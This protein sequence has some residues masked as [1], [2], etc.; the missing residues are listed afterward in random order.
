ML[1]YVMCMMASAM[2][3]VPSPT[4]ENGDVQEGGVG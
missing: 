2:D 1:A 3:F 4:S